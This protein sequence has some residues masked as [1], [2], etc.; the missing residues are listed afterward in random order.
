MAM[1]LNYCYWLCNGK[2]NLINVLVRT[3][4]SSNRPNQRK[5]RSSHRVSRTRIHKPTM[6]RSNPPINQPA[7]SKVA[8]SPRTPAPRRRARRR[9]TSPRRGRTT[10]GAALL[11]PIRF[12]DPPYRLLHLCPRSAF[13]FDSFLPDIGA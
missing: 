10:S 12:F 2:S 13:D 1:S 3:D 11:T 6:A 5:R 4:V 9:P 7:S 8:S